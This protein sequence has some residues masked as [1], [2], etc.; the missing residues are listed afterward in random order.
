MLSGLSLT[1][2]SAV[3][4]F[5]QRPIHTADPEP[6]KLWFVLPM[7]LPYAVIIATNVT[8]WA[9]VTAYSVQIVFVF[10]VL[11]L[12]VKFVAQV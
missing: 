2:N 3:C 6:S 1:Y 12:L 5:A 9:F 8:A 11:T 4:F 10:I 7:C